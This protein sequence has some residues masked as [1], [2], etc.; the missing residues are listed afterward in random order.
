[1]GQVRGERRGLPGG[2]P[3]DHGLSSI[4]AWALMLYPPKKCAALPYGV[5]RSCER[6]VYNLSGM[7]AAEA[8]ALIRQKEGCWGVRLLRR[9]DGTILTADCP[10]GLRSRL[11]K[12]R[13]R[14][15]LPGAVKA[16]CLVILLALAAFAWLAGFVGGD[17]CATMGEPVEK[18]FRNGAAG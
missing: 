2:R 15:G 17:G 7:R 8:L 1:R 9:A 14:A 16:A 18:D 10:E 11:D 5:P 4:L 6:V 13:R 3:Q 12:Y